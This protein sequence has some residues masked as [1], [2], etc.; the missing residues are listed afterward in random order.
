[1]RSDARRAPAAALAL[2]LVALPC[3]CILAM[4][5][6]PLRDG[7]ARVFDLM[8]AAL[9]P[10][11]APDWP[12]RV[13]EIGALDAAGR[14]WDRAASARLAAVLADAGPRLVAWDLVFAGRCAAPE[15]AALAAAV[16]RVPTVLGLLMQ[17]A[18]GAAPGTPA[19]PWAVAPDLAGT[20]WSAPGAELPCAEL[21]V[22]GVSL[23]SLAL[24][25][26][27]DGRVRAVPAA[28]LAGGRVWPGLA[29]E[30][31]R[32]I[33]GAGLGMAAPGRLRIGARDW[34]LEAGGL[35]RLRPT[36]PAVWAARR[37]DAAALLADPGAAAALA[38]AVVLVGVTAPQAG[39]LRATAADPLHPSVQIAADAVVALA[40]GRVPLRP[41]PAPWVE[42]AGLALMALLGAV[43]VQRLAAPLALGVVLG[44]SALWAGGAVLALAVADR[45]VDPA[46]PALALVA[47]ALLGLTVRA[48]ASQRAERALRRRMGQLLPPEIVAALAADPGL[49]RL[50]G[51]ARVVTA[52]FTDLEGFT[53]LVTR[54]PPETVIARLEAY[55]PQIVGA[56]L[57]EGGMVDKIVG[58][59]V[60]ALFN[61]PLDRPD[62][63]AAALRAARA[64]LARTEALRAR[65]EG[66]GLGRTR[67][68]IETGRA[69]LGDVGAGE[70][71]DYTAH[72]PAVNLAARL[73][74]VARD[75]GVAV[76]VGPGTAAA[77]G[78]AGLV[79]L[80][81]REVRSFGVVAIHTLADGVPPPGAVGGGGVG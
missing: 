7:Q 14:A 62:H 44:L 58:D 15:T 38:G 73:Q 9:P 2:M 18:E 68:G 27:G 29:A 77:L 32:R 74:E 36:G 70:R 12:L 42:G 3:A 11:P 66:E 22:P 59:G 6:A 24:P 37:V 51:E 61:A 46:G 64:I 41:A 28:I 17:G 34:G 43:A 53:A 25:G 52:L 72:G 5:P 65:P 21:L 79:P 31:L 55:F 54:A 50:K 69:V 19:V 4:A 39:G 57:A 48:A 81:T 47:A 35:M 71:I 8:L 16:A 1:M 49:L 30:V 40:A 13:V 78:G 26:A 63:A 60:H 33:E 80:A 75:L 23:A 76:A 67:I 56:I 20:L 45:L 10:P